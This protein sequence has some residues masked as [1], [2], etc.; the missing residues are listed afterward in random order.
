MIP[1]LSS[2]N[3]GNAYDAM[4]GLFCLL[5]GISLILAIYGSVLGYRRKI[6]V[7]DSK[8]DITVTSASI[9]S[10]AC[11]GIAFGCRSEAPFAF[12]LLLLLSVILTI[13]A[14]TRSARANKTAWGATLSV[15]AKYALLALITLCAL[16]AVGGAFAAIDETKKKQYKQAAADAAAGAVGAAGVF[17][18]RKLI[19]QLITENPSKKL[20]SR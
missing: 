10:W 3:Q 17:A 15:F 4:I 1:L 14:I 5:G 13:N 9:I 19:N 6:V 7:Y 11:T 12:W 8:A 20:K 18:V 2:A 16:I